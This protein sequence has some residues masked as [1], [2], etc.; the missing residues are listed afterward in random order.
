MP[1]TESPGTNRRLRI[2]FVHRFDARKISSWSGI[3]FFMSRAL[4]THVGEVV[5]LGPDNSAGT[6]FIIDNTARV[7]RYWQRLTGKTLTTDKNRIL[8]NRLAR[9]FERRIEESP[10]DILFA[11]VASV[12]I[13]HLKTDLPIV[14]YS[15]LTWA[16]IVDYY[17]EFS[18]VSDYGRAEGER[19]EALAIRRSNACVYP[20]DW[21]ANSACDD[22]GAKR[23]T[24]CKV[25][26]GANL[27][28][29]PSR[30]QALNRR[31]TGRVNLLLVGVDWVRKGGAIAFECLT[32]LVDSGVDAHL[33]IMG[34]VPPPSFEHPN[35]RVI[36]FLNKNEPEQRKQIEQL[37]LDAH[38]M[39]LPTRADATP[40]VTCE[41]SAFGLP[42]LATDTGGLG[43]S[44]EN[45]VNGFL[46]PYEARG[47]AYADKIRSIIA[48]PAQYAALVAFSRDAFEHTLNWDA[49]GES[50]RLVMERVLNREIDPGEPV[51]KTP[52]NESMDA[53]D[54]LQDQESDSPEVAISLAAEISHS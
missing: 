50:M 45:G 16:Q 1:Y 40:I 11:P 2:G 28:D 53:H 3:F 19:I 30:Q 44:I 48:D 7:N 4:E 42:T 52:A 17:P 25:S 49:W 13:A 5:Y 29:P 9:F 37:F 32:S 12:E 33:T 34:C 27:N 39:L 6:K 46:L 36:P 14:Y 38:F 8:S 26:F 22:Y 23:E 41:A 51:L 18:G 47:Q 31:L 24:T 20:S 21:A 35:L 10:C 43:G 54:P 15:D